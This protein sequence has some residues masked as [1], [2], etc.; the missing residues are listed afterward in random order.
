MTSSSKRR[1]SRR[2]RRRCLSCIRRFK[3]CPRNH[4][5]I[6]IIKPCLRTQSPT[7]T[8]SVSQAASPTSTSSAARTTAPC[9]SA[10]ISAAASA[11][12]ITFRPLNKWTKTAPTISVYLFS[13]RQTQ[14]Q[15]C[16][17]CLLLV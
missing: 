15:R 14:R 3:K 7:A 8:S 10:K 13:F 2:K 4:A 12:T 11:P 6:F 9:Y 1:R 17:L 5:R 16:W